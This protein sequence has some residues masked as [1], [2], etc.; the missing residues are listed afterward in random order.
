V[1]APTPSPSTGAVFLSYARDDAAAARRL[2]EALRSAGIEVWFDENELRGGDA[3]DAKIRRQID[4]CA[5]FVPLISQHTQGRTKGYFRLEWKLAVDQTH[6]LAAGVPFLAPVA[7]DDTREADAI[8]P[9]EFMRVQWTRLPGALPTPQFV[10]QIKRLLDS[11]DTPAAL[12]QPPGGGFLGAGRPESAAPALPAPRRTVPVWWWAAPVAIALGVVATFI[13]LRK[14]APVPAPTAAGRAPA[15]APVTPAV[16]APA[17]KSI[18]VLPFANLSPDAE[19]AFF[20]DGMH[21]DLITA[22]AK[23]RDLKVI[24]RTSV[25]PYKT[26]ARNLRKIAEELGVA[27]VLE[28]SV[29]RAGQ[30]VRL[31]IQLIDA[32]TDAHLWAETYNQELTDVFTIQAALTGEIAAALKA[33]LTQ[34]ERALIARRPTENQAAY[35]LYMQARILDQKIGIS[36]GREEYERVLDLLGR[37][38]ALDP[39]FALAQAQTAMLHGQLFW[40]SYLDPSPARR[41]L[42]QASLAAAL[43]L[44]PGSPEVQLAQGT[45]AYLCDN[46]WTRALEYFQAAETGLPNDFQLHYRAALA[47]RRRGELLAARV[48]LERAADLNPNDVRGIFTLIET[49]QYLRRYPQVVALAERYRAVGAGD[50]DLQAF[51]VEAQFQLDGNVDRYRRDWA[52]LPPR[53]SD[54]LG[55]ERDYLVAY[56]AGDLAGAERVL[57]DPRLKTVR[58]AG[59]VVSEPVALHRAQLA[60]LQGREAEARRWADEALAHY[61][62]RDWSVRQKPVVQLDIARAEALA[63]RKESALAGARAALAAQR[64]LDALTFANLRPLMGQLLVV[65]GEREEALAL[66]RECYV[67]TS[68]ISMTPAAIRRDPFWV[69]LKDD[70]RFE[71]ILRGV[72]PL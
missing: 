47:H 24:S 2:A 14:P 41:A 64:E 67:G 54:G 35:D 62:G 56:R 58:G 38:V 11:R 53:G 31:N 65:C 9:P 61:R 23:I 40:F 51:R 57:A 72:Q 21:D 17:G 18:A 7:I 22:L 20:A 26:G 15:A 29:Q 32:R 71:E 59:G 44:A 12:P 5:L 45:V 6:L 25:M 66:L 49:N 30:R 8:V 48:K 37:A 27:T 3:W 4:T 68:I 13:A 69:R 46:D 39:K 10:G 52:A 60:W 43:R 70:P 34:G 42:A 63:G 1:P 16:P 50:F 19:N 36:S 33:N 28:G 55:L